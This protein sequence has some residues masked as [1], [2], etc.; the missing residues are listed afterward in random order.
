MSEPLEAAN[1]EQHEGSHAARREGAEQ[2][3][4]ESARRSASCQPVLQRFYVAVG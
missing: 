4:G 2:Q 3:D 1:Y